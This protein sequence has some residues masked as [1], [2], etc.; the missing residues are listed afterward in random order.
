M[1]PQVIL[2]VNIDASR[3]GYAYA[4]R[5]RV[6]P[7]DVRRLHVVFEGQKS[8]R[9]DKF[10]RAGAWVVVQPAPS[11]SLRVLGRVEDVRL[12]RGRREDGTGLGALFDLTVVRVDPT[13]APCL[14]IPEK[15]RAHWRGKPGRHMREAM[16]AWFGVAGGIGNVQSGVVVM[17]RPS[18]EP[19]LV[20]MGNGGVQARIRGSARGQAQKQY[21]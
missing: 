9:A 10:V 1:A 17:G 7:D 18:F 13:G 8:G 6:M 4:D 21:L 20:A 2:R 14:E 12:Q 11:Q 19:A 15:M 16:F 5:I 3:P